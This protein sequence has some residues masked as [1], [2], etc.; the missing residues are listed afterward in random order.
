MII[1][2]TD[3]DSCFKRLKA[4]IFKILFDKILH[5][6]IY[7]YVLEPFYGWFFVVGAH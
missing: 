6:M 3:T 5:F 2:V 1:F 4:E 7:F